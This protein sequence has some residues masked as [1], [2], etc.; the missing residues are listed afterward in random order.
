MLGIHSYKQPEPAQKQTTEP[1]TCT[2]TTEQTNNTGSIY[3][4]TKLFHRGSMGPDFGQAQ[5][6]MEQTQ[7]K[8]P[9]SHLAR[10]RTQEQKGHHSGVTQPVTIQDNGYTQRYLA[11]TEPKPS[12]KHGTTTYH[13]VARNPLT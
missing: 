6:P 11:T 5:A 10:T 4:S 7:T 2:S 3:V 13:S 1:R 8:T 9:A 12:H